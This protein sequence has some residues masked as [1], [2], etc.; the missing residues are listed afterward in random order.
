[1][2]DPAVPSPVD[3]NLYIIAIHKLRGE[4]PGDGSLKRGACEVVASEL[5]LHRSVGQSV[6][7]IADQ[8]AIDLGP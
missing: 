2:P 3:R 4:G 6:G 1:M 8:N 7:L 5:S